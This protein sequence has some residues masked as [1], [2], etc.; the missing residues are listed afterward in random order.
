MKNTILATILLATASVALAGSPMCDAKRSQREMAECYQY[1]VNGAQ[2]RMQKNYERLTTSGRV[3]NE[4]ADNINEAHNAWAVNTNN[5]CQD[6]R[7]V[8]DALQ[9]RISQVEKIMHKHGLQPY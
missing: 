4:E 3:S 9:T 6:N 7:C 2:L 5:R 8:Y 1:S